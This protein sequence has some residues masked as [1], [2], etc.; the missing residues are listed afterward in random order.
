MPKTCPSESRAITLT[1][2][3]LLALSI[4]AS[5]FILYTPLGEPTIM[6]HHWVAVEALYLSS[7]VRLH[8]TP[9]QLPLHFGLLVVGVETC[10][11]IPPRFVLARFL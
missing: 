2:I 6:V 5:Q 1:P 11:Q 4:A 3:I 8:R 7:V 10:H 9:I